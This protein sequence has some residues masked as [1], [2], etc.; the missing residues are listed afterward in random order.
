MKPLVAH[1][2][3]DEIWEIQKQINLKNNIYI[4]IY[5]YIYMYMYI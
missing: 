3:D 5:I 2:C 4:Y 1:Q